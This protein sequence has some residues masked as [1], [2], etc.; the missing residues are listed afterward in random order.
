MNICRSVDQRPATS[1]KDVD[2]D[3]DVVPDLD[4]DGNVDVD[5]TVDLAR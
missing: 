2:L 4:D 1:S 5:S 3:L